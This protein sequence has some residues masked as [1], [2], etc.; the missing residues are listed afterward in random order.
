MSPLISNCYKNWLDMYLDIHRVV[1]LS[2]IPHIAIKAGV[3]IQQH[4]C[5][6]D[7]Q[8][9]ISPCQTGVFFNP[10][11]GSLSLFF[12]WPV[13]SGTMKFIP[14]HSHHDILCDVVNS[15]IP[16][17]SPQSHLQCA[18]CIPEMAKAKECGSEL[19]SDR[20]LLI[21]QVVMEDQIITNGGSDY[22]KALESDSHI[23]LKDLRVIEFVFSE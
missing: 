4:Q 23:R 5:P 21:L 14:A 6:I 9:S 11:L 19:L 1:W 10:L 7:H 15:S 3:S 12:I 18:G 13:Q 8:P 16:Y 20:V 2:I 22:I 17:S